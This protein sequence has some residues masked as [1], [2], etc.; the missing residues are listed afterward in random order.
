MEDWKERFENRF[1]GNTVKLGN[2]LRFSGGIDPLV[3]IEIETFISEERRNLVKSILRE[4]DKVETES[5]GS[6]FEEWREYKHIRNRIV[7]KF[8][9]DKNENKS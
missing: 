2:T 9:I 4:I 8:L 1:V 5:K 6:S 3:V 7:D